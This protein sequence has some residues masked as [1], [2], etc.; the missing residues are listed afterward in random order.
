MRKRLAGVAMAASL[1]A[2]V[3]VAPAQAQDLHCMPL[4]PDGVGCLVRCHIW[5]VGDFVEGGGADPG[6]VCSHWG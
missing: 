1:L 6:Y 2:A 3:P 4:L 5:W